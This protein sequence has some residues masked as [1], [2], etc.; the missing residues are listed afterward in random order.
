[1]FQERVSLIQVNVI[2]AQVTLLDFGPCSS[3]PACR[4][5]IEKVT[6]WFPTGMP[7]AIYRKPQ[8]IQ[9]GEET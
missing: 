6:T 5:E 1:M 8:K 2:D 7:D 4:L 3:L 9:Q